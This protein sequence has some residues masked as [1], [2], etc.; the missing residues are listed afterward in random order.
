MVGADTEGVPTRER[1]KTAMD[2][3]CALRQRE[4][5]I[6][7]R[8]REAA[9]DARQH[10][11][12]MRQRAVDLE[13]QLDDGA[14]VKMCECAS[15]SEG[16]SEVRE[17]VCVIF[18]VV[19]FFSLCVNDARDLQMLALARNVRTMTCRRASCM[20]AT[21]TAATTGPTCAGRGLTVAWRSGLC[22]TTR[23]C[24]RC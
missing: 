12:R 16:V 11:E 3:L 5:A 2:V 10:C 13:R 17:G 14:C 19:F 4:S 22:A 6:E 18:F 7:A 23:W 20:A 9:D 1:M 24:N 8:Q 21:P 15:V